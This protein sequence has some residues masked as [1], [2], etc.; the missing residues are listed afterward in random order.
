M[1]VRLITPRRFGDDRGW[2]AE[3]FSAHRWAEAGIAGSFVQDNHSYS[4]DVGTLR[5]LHFQTP[6]FA[7]GK[8]VRCVRGAVWDVAVDLRKGSPTYGGHVAAEL[9][10]EAGTQ[11]WVPAGF[12][13]GFVTLR[14]DSEVEYKVTAYYS[15]THDSGLAWDDPDLAI[16][17]P[18]PPGR[19]PVL[20]G[21]DARLGRLADFVSP[22]VYD[23]VPLTLTTA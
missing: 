13:H 4:R 18:L 14:P 12:A 10:A 9:T 22:F 15:P 21:K 8:L 16:P 1:A 3:T 19:A 23:G 5:G 6:P 2:F 7:Q 11:I 20:S 17:W